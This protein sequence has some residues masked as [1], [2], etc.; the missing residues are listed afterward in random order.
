MLPLELDVE[1]VGERDPWKLPALAL[2]VF[3]VTLA[4]LAW[5]LGLLAARDDR[6]LS[7]GCG[8]A[9]VFCLI[10]IGLLCHPPLRRAGARSGI[11]LSAILLAVLAFLTLL[12]VAYLIEDWKDW[13]QALAFLL[14]AAIL[15]GALTVACVG[16][17]Q[18]LRYARSHPWTE[19]DADA[20]RAN[21]S[22]AAAGWS[23]LVTGKPA[24]GSDLGPRSGG[25]FGAAYPLLPLAAIVIC[26]AAGIARLSIRHS[27]AP[28]G[29]ANELTNKADRAVKSVLPACIAQ[30]VAKHGQ[31]G[32]PTSLNEVPC[33]DLAPEVKQHF[34]ISYTPEVTDASGVIRSY[35]LCAAPRDPNRFDRVFVADDVNHSSGSVAGLPPP[36]GEDDTSTWAACAAGWEGNT[37]QQIRTCAIHYARQHP[38]EGYPPSLDALTSCLPPTTEKARRANV[39]W[40][41]KYVPSRPDAAGLIRSF[42]IRRH[43]E[44]LPQPFTAVLAEPE[45]RDRG[46]WRLQR[47]FAVGPSGAVLDEST[48]RPPAG[49]VP[50]GADRPDVSRT[51]T[52]L[53]GPQVSSRAS[54][55]AK[56]TN[57][58]PRSV[59][60]TLRDPDSM[61]LNNLAGELH[62]IGSRLLGE[63]T[64]SGY[65]AAEIALGDGRVGWFSLDVGC[66]PLKLVEL[67]DDRR[68][69]LVLVSLTLSTQP[70]GLFDVPSNYTEGP[71]SSLEAI[72]DNCDQQC[73]DRR[74][75][76]FQVANRT[77]FENRQR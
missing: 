47:T 59:Y 18:T 65:R 46:S 50:T 51:V 42:S 9:E 22:S 8:V 73:I 15:N 33:A 44:L 7:R 67:V 69:V 66:A 60:E 6:W 58:K 76:K 21:T 1:S 24:G 61:C 41:N 56:S 25:R 34:L 5:G 62:T 16:S 43:E 30:Y 77:Y 54:L 19:P 20:G 52:R 45:S 39:V 13:P 14:P 35:M 75:R 26:V 28:R 31:P 72:P 2:V 38:A 29:S 27:T 32:Y 17:V 57:W 11:V 36:T 71:P 68:V 74:W 64:M 55:K 53:D 10:V 49:H 63:S 12:L 70:V 4:A 3:G 23:E 37:R 48:T 40:L